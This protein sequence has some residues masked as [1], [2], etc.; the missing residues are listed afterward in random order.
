MDMLYDYNPGFR[1][2]ISETV[3]FPSYD[4]DNLIRILVGTLKKNHFDLDPATHDAL[5]AYFDAARRTPDFGNAGAVRSLSERAI[6]RW[7]ARHASKIA[8]AGQGDALDHVIQM[9]DLKHIIKAAR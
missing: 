7:K 3:V 9:E 1:R 5:Y 6:S 8:A 4:A 2:R